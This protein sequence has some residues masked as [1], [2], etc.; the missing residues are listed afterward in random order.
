MSSSD[1]A[2]GDPLHH[3][4]VLP[5]RHLLHEPPAHPADVDR[6]QLPCRGRQHR[7]VAELL[8]QLGR[9]TVRLVGG[10]EVHLGGRRRE[11]LTDPGVHKCLPQLHARGELGGQIVP[12]DRE[13]SHPSREL[14][15]AIVLLRQPQRGR[16]AE[17][18]I[19]IQVGVAEGLG[20]G[21]KLRQSLQAIPGPPEH[22]QG[23][24]PRGQQTEPLLRRRRLRQ[25]DLHDA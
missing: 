9:A 15:R 19:E 2:G 17:R 21:G 22:L 24:V 4:Q 11:P 1:F 7:G 13:R 5:Y 14:R 6:P 8:R 20:Q 3:R 10:I 12:F 18:D 16:A 23:V 25:R